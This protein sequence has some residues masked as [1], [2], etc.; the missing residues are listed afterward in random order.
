MSLLRLWRVDSLR[1]EKLAALFASHPPLPEETWQWSRE[2]GLQVSEV[3]LRLPLLRALNYPCLLTDFA[4]GEGPPRPVILAALSE[5]RAEIFDPLRGRMDYP[6]E[7][8]Q[9]SWG[10]RGMVWWR[11][12]EGLRLPLEYT[13]PN[14]DVMR[15]QTVLSQQGFYQGKLDGWFG[16]QTEAA[17]AAFQRRSGLE[18][19]GRLDE[20]T[21]A[22]LSRAQGGEGAD[23]PRLNKAGKG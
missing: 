2:F 1:L 7:K 15:L 19:T 8:V 6:L 20:I 4:E 9:A 16:P 18:G 17:L 14:A 10:K 21:L 5:Q 11:G 3:P 13:R 22:V 12:I 23:L